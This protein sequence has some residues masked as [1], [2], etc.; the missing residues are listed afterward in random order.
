ML[1][2]GRLDQRDKC[3]DDQRD[4]FKAA[5]TTVDDGNL[6]RADIA[7]T[8]IHITLGPNDREISERLK[9]YLF[10]YNVDYRC[11]EFREVTLTPDK[12]TD[13]DHEITPNFLLCQSMF[14]QCFN[15]NVI[16]ETGRLT[17]KENV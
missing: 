17:K 4:E 15:C 14:S 10:K 2:K 16:D 9:A 6:R 3:R 7:N 1:K 13:L 12:Y 11:S 5:L 8:A